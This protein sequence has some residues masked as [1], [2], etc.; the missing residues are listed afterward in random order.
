MQNDRNISIIWNLAYY[1]FIAEV[2]VMAQQYL[3][4]QKAWKLL[5]DL[6][7]EA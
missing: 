7:I 1:T 2:S 4:F 5:Y 3:L 6:S